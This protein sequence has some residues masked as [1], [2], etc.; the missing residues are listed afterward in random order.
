MRGPVALSTAWS[1]SAHDRPAATHTQA[2]EWQ[3]WAAAAG[4]LLLGAACHGCGRPWW[5]VCPP[6][7][8]EL[9]RHRPYLAM[10]D[11]CP[12]RFPLTATSSAYGP[13]LRE[14]INAHKERQALGLTGLLGGRLAL[15]VAELMRSRPPAAT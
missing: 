14:L 13:L 7:R 9:D 5:G 2:V 8:D 4:D 3:R 10:P 15:S 6:C 1:R 12:P 11:P